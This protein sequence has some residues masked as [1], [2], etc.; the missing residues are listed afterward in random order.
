VEP[1]PDDFLQARAL[2]QTDEGL[3]SRVVRRYDPHVEVPGG[4][5]CTVEDDVESHPDYCV[6]P[7]TL[8][9]LLLEAFNAGAAGD[10]PREQ[11]A[12][13]EGAL[14]WF[15]YVSVMAVS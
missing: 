2:Y 7:A 6:G 4:A 3:D 5:D 11:A 10:A 15:F 12:R 8:Q 14:L 13:I 1:S 9:P